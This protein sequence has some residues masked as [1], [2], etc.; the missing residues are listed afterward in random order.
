MQPQYNVYYNA[1]AIGHATENNLH[2]QRLIISL[3][4][5]RTQIQCNV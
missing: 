3:C 4:L 1:V 2:K 5:A